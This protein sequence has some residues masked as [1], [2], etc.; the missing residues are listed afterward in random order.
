MSFSSLWFRLKLLTAKEPPKS[1][2]W[3]SLRHNPQKRFQRNYF[4]RWAWSKMILKMIIKMSYKYENIK[5]KHK[6]S[7]VG[8]FQPRTQ[9]K[10]P[11]S[12]WNWR[13][14]WRRKKKNRALDNKVRSFCG[15]RQTH[16]IYENLSVMQ[17]FLTKS[18]FDRLWRFHNLNA[19]DFVEKS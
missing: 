15:T 17:I 16:K 4:L 8:I 7:F 9:R 18:R 1:M 13:W 5:C 6:T 12:L 3:T 19:N 14:N 2:S 11:K 10:T